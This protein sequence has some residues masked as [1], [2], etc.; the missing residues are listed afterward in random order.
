MR[1]FAGQSTSGLAQGLISKGHNRERPP[2][3]LWVITWC[4]ASESK[5]RQSLFAGPAK[6]RRGRSSGSS[7]TFSLQR[8]RE[9]PE[10]RT[11][12]S[13]TCTRLPERWPVPHIDTQPPTV[14]LHPSHIQLGCFQGLPTSYLWN[15][16]A[17]LPG[18]W[19]RAFGGLS[20]MVAAYRRQN[21]HE[22][23]SLQPEGRD[24]AP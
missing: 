10:R 3:G 1:A 15:G 24:R 7:H 5:D 8:A 22:V 19:V 4:S 11:W 21:A 14:G 12:L 23:F 16:C 20:T 6:A 2:H 13:S 18:H 17:K 9:P